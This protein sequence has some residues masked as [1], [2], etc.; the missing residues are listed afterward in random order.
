MIRTTFA[1]ALIVAVTLAAC[2]SPPGAATHDE[3]STGTSEEAIR[4]A[5]RDRCDL[6]QVI[7]T[8]L[9]PL[10]GPIRGVTREVKLSSLPPRVRAELTLAT[11]EIRARARPDLAIDIEGY[12]SI[13]ATPLVVPHGGTCAKGVV[14]YAVLGFAT[15]EP[16]F[17]AGVV[18]A[19]DRT[20]KR[21]A[22]YED[23]G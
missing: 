18:I 14:A 23:D 12:Y 16:D 17:H 1:L 2:A 11:K 22:S 13:L 20:G 4:R 19:V 6:E 9:P 21:V 10:G 7:R 15:G 3:D 8:A 5:G